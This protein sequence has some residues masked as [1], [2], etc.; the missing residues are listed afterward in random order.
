MFFFGNNI[1]AYWALGRPI[2]AF[3]ANSDMFY[4]VLK[5]LLVVESSE[6]KIVRCV[7]NLDDDSPIQKRAKINLN[8]E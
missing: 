2:L 3:E 5:P 4:E 8:C 7:F 6:T 1:H